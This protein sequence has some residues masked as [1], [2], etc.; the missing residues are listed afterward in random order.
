[1]RSTTIQIFNLENEPR[2]SSSSIPGGKK[3]GWRW[4]KR[5]RWG[6]PSGRI[7]PEPGNPALGMS[8]R[9]PAYNR[10]IEKH[11]NMGF[12]IEKTAEIYGE[13]RCFFVVFWKSFFFQK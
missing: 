4:E 3:P 2:F 12:Q 7:N 5:G 6:N 9:S 13:I 11:L 1:M 8:F 10:K